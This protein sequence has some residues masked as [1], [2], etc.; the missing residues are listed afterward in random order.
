LLRGDHDPFGPKMGHEAI[1]I[2]VW[3]V[4]HSQQHVDHACE[5]KAALRL[6][7]ARR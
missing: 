3:M 5:I 4:D 1:D 6:R 2:V 7:C